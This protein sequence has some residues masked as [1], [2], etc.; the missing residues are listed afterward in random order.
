MRTSFKLGILI[1]A[2]LLLALPVL[3]ACSDDDETEQPT[4]MPTKTTTP[5]KTAAPTETT[6][7]TETATPPPVEDVVITIG[8]LTDL[9]GPASGMLGGP[10]TALKVGVAYFN[11]ENLIPGVELEIESYDG[12]MDPSRDIPGYEWLKERGADVMYSV[13]PQYGIS[14]FDR[15]AEDKMALLCLS[16]PNEVV[17][18]EPGW[19]F[20]YSPPQRSIGYTQLKWLADNHWDWEANGPAKIGGA[21]WDEPFSAGILQ[22]MEDYCKAHPDQFEWIGGYL[23][24]YTPTWGPE[25]AALK[26]ADYVMPAITAFGFTGF[27]TEY[28][29]VGGTAQFIC[30]EGHAGSLNLLDAAG[31]W[32]LM[33]GALFIISQRSVS[34]DTEMNGLM[35]DATNKYADNHWLIP[36]EGAHNYQSAWRQVYRTLALIGQA[37]EDAG[38]AQN[39]TPEQIYETASTFS[40]SMDN[41]PARTW[42][43]E[44][45]TFPNVMAMYEIK[46]DKS[47]L[48]YGGGEP[49]WVP[50]VYEP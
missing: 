49:V 13:F 35:R 36:G 41:D 20:M 17:E 18:A 6:A 25:V 32:D 38:G 11:D 12:Q 24:M 43:P 21:S 27:I 14:L 10:E 16:S 5:T 34:E 42:T 2:V 47:I 19:V 7:P 39:F 31:A 1:L 26:D 28:R 3:A 44:K 30:N 15:L 9:T 8:N 33:D 46:A 45:R 48:P 22:G 23:T 40:Y 37:V 50:I 4:A 29:D